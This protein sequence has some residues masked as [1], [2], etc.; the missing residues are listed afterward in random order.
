MLTFSAN[1]K[2]RYTDRSPSMFVRP[3][4]KETGW[5]VAFFRLLVLLREASSDV[6]RGSSCSRATPEVTLG[7]VHPTTL[8]V[9]NGYDAD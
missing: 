9:F 5:K 4:A 2:D 6:S 3:Q 1:G 7:S 8:L